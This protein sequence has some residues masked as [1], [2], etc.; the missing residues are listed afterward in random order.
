MLSDIGRRLF[1]AIA[2][3]PDSGLISMFMNQT[4]LILFFSTFRL[5]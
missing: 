2:V 4:L 5:S 3:V 1:V